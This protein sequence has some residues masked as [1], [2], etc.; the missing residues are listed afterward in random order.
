MVGSY[1]TA[2]FIDDRQW[3]FY[4]GYWTI[5]LLVFRILWGFFGPRHARF[6]SFI[7]T[8]LGNL[9]VRQRDVPAQ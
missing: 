5:G 1:V 6:T 8:A 9:A 2:K 3:H 7:R 4:V